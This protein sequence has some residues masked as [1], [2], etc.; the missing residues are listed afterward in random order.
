MKYQLPAQ[1]S[2]TISSRFIEAQGS[3]DDRRSNTAFT[4]S[5]TSSCTQLLW[6]IDMMLSAISLNRLLK[7]NAHTG[8]LS[9]QDDEASLREF[10]ITEIC[11]NRF[12]HFQFP[13]FWT[14]NFGGT[15]ILNIDDRVISAIPRVESRIRESR[16]SIWGILEEMLTRLIGFIPRLTCQLV[17]LGIKAWNFLPF[18]R[19]SRWRWCLKNRKNSPNMINPSST[20]IKYQITLL[21]AL[22]FKTYNIKC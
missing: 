12:M 8:I 19:T 13:D 9:F 10:T 5:N 15:F 17:L 1:L 2:N 14:L 11:W 21:T 18:L 22:R 20:S 3:I 4:S 6:I 7:R 16:F